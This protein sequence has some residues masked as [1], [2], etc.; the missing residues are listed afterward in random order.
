MSYK[1]KNPKQKETFGSVCKL[2][3]KKKITRGMDTSPRQPN[4]TTVKDKRRESEKKP[5]WINKED[6]D[7]SQQRRANTSSAP[8]YFSNLEPRYEGECLDSAARASTESF[9]QGSPDGPGHLGVP[10][11]FVS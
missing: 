3:K 6:G 2:I 8:S 10:K 7:P 4:E 9:Y 1:K 5:T 11:I